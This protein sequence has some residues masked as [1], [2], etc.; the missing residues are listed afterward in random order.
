VAKLFGLLLGYLFGGGGTVTAIVN[1]LTQ[2]HADSI[3]AKSETEKVEAK[4]R[5]DTL[6]AAL[7]DVQRAR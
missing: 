1:A 7:A 3:N 2:A 4:A 5:I 6:N